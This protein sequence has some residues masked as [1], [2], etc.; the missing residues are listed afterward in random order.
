MSHQR[1]RRC[2]DLCPDFP[3]CVS[4]FSPQSVCITSLPSC[5]SFFWPR[6]FLRCLLTWCLKSTTSWATGRTVRRT[7]ALRPAGWTTRR[8]TVPADSPSSHPGHR[9]TGLR[10][11][12]WSSLT[13]T[14]RNKLQGQLHILIRTRSTGSSQVQQ[15]LSAASNH[16]RPF[17][18]HP[19][20]Q[21]QLCRD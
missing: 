11:S 9:H 14:A 5:L 1:N 19:F 8:S 7:T 12:P 3:P 2:C 10:Y 4:T 15:T 21:T 13:A 17:A 20:I 16:L 18:Q 6:S